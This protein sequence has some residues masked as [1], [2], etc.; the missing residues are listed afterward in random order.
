MFT[1][2]NGVFPKFCR[3][4]DNDTETLVRAFVT[5]VR[6]LL[7]YCTPVWSPSSVGMIKRVESVHRAFTKKLPNLKCLT[8]KKRLSTVGLESLE[9]R[10]LKADL[11]T[12]FKILKGFTNIIP[13][14]FFYVV[15]M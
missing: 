15:V 5:C 13:S 1:T 10:R 14:E 7:E 8:Y 4:V 12:C 3:M 6:P 11:I 2:D 9:L